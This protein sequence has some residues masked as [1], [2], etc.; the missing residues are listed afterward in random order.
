MAIVGLF[1]LS[2]FN[3]LVAL[4]NTARAKK[5][6]RNIILF[7]TSVWKNWRKQA[8]KYKKNLIASKLVVC[9]QIYIEYFIHNAYYFVHF[10]H[11]HSL[12][13]SNARSF[14]RLFTHKCVQNVCVCR[15]CM[16][17][18]CFCCCFFSPLL[19]YAHIYNLCYKIWLFIHFSLAFGLKLWSFSL[20]NA[21]LIR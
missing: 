18:C 9:I 7:T 13:H 11:S 2:L 5:N 19:T 12:A 10:S 4:N 21:V 16:C 6:R 3:K 8:T 20:W 1:K 17:W 15:E 14:V